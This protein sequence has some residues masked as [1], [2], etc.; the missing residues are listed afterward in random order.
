[1][2]NWRSVNIVGTCDAAEV[3]KLKAACLFDFDKPGEGK[4][5]SWH[6]LSWSPRP[7]LCGLNDWVSERISAIG[8]LAERDYSVEDVAATLLKLVA[9]APSLKIK[10]HCGGD[11]E[12]KKC[13]NTIIVAG[14]IVTVGAPEV[15]T[16]MEISQ[17]AFNGNFLRAIY[18][19]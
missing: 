15:E 8:N 11:Y 6:C 10:V 2:G 19:L 9:V 4:W 14:G 5:D 7:S 1:M 3:E 12:D 13:I 16:L 18:G 17:A